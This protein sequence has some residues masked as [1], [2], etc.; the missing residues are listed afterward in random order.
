MITIREIAAIAGVSRSTVSLVLNNSPLVKDETRQRVLKVIESTGYV[1]NSNARNL[2]WN[3][4]KS[5][6]IVVLSDHEPCAD[7]T[8]AN[9]VGLYALNIINGITARLADTPYS[10]IMENF[11]PG[12]RTSD[13]AAA[14]EG[15]PRLPKL[16]RERKVDGAF[17][18]GGY[19][20]PELLN[21]CAATGIPLVT[22]GIGAPDMACDSVISDP[23]D[24]TCSAFQVLRAR[25]RTR[26][27]LVNCPR[28]FISAAMRSEGAARF[29]TMAGVPFDGSTVLYAEE[30]SGASAYR[31][32]KEAWD[33]GLRY[34]GL[35]A[36]N[37]QC[38]LGVIR[39]FAERNIRIPDEV[40]VIAYE[41]NAMC[42]YAT[43]AV[44]AYNIQKERMGATA[45]DLML[46]RLE[47]PTQALRSVV[48]PSYLVNR[49]SA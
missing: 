49:E 27:A 43:P 45:V 15:S 36:A 11:T 28:M 31:A 23:A 34:D 26:L 20:E 22:V 40:A 47:D 3:T 1:P 4:T 38:A 7:Y 29:A 21:A 24:A 6:G 30:N 8:F 14:S 9:T 16:I 10:V 44:T 13:E 18:V 19:R 33:K 39:F 32:I 48:I 17:L 41:D 2:N 25:G 37:P 46:S 12:I 35:V 42:A 5:L